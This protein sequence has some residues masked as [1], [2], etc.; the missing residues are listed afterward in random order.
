MHPEVAYPMHIDDNNNLDL[1]PRPAGQR[2]PST[3]ER[4]KVTSTVARKPR[5]EEGDE[6]MVT[7]VESKREANKIQPLDLPRGHVNDSQLPHVSPC[8]ATSTS[9]PFIPFSIFPPRSPSIYL[10]YFC[11]Y[12]RVGYF[13]YQ[14]PCCDSFD[15]WLL[16]LWFKAASRNNN[17]GCNKEKI[18][19]CNFSLGQTRRYLCRFLIAILRYQGNLISSYHIFVLSVCPTRVLDIDWLHIA[20]M[21]KPEEDDASFGNEPKKSSVDATFIATMST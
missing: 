13:Y 1:I 5:R 18:S 12:A 9:H 10:V 20:P 19:M 16:V 2:G 14:S 3:P 11:F 8:L 21:M 7:T 6:L 15:F 17:K 4:L